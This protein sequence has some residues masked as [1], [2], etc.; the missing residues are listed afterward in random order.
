M[1]NYLEKLNDKQKEACIDVYGPS[2]IIA[3]AGSGKTRVLTNR[4]AYMIDNEKINPRNI[5]AITFTNKA[6]KEMKTRLIDMIGDYSGVVTCKTFH[7]FG[8]DILRRDIESLN[9]RKKSFQIIDDDESEVIVKNVM[10]KLNMDL[11]ITKPKTFLNSISAIKSKIKTY[12]DYEK[13]YADKLRNI[14][15]L[16]NEELKKN[17]LLDFDDLIYLPI[18]IFDLYPEILE[19]YQ[20]RYKYIMVDEFQD[21]SNIQYEFVEKLGRKHRNVFIV[22]DEDQSIY[23]FRGANI[24]NIRKFME[25]FPEYHKHV[26]D[27]NYRSTQSILTCANNLIKNNSDRI[28]KNLWTASKTEGEVGLYQFES[29]YAETRAVV[30]IIKAGIDSGKYKYSDYAILYRNNALSRIFEQELLFSNIPHRVL[31]GLSFYKRMEVKD[32][33]GFLRLSINPNDFYSFKRVCNVPPKGLGKTTID[34]IEERM[35]INGGNLKD[36]IETIE[37]Y[38]NTRKALRDF[39]AFI[40]SIVK[41]LD[42]NTVTLK[43]VFEYVYKESGYKKYLEDIEDENERESRQQNI[44]ELLSAI[45]EEE[46]TESIKVTLADFLQNVTLLTDQD[47]EYEDTNYVSL[48]SMHSAKG[49]EFTNVFAVCLEDEVLPGGKIPGMDEFYE[50]RRLFYVCL[51]RAKENLYIMYSNSRILYGRTESFYPSRFLKELKLET[52][53]EKNNPDRLSMQTKHVTREVP[54]GD[55]KPGDRIIHTMLGEGVILGQAEGFYIVRY[56]SSP[57]PKKIIIGHPMLKKK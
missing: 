30:Q 21:T 45:S 10:Q 43:D 9:G 22:G 31:S 14:F 28:E 39:Y 8:A 40:E 23:S 41:L 24:K 2:L 18:K 19:K 44:K 32:M 17:N 1:K 57:N 33:M 38:D 7:S 34:K 46:S 50:E 49:L 42:E 52:R 36:A 55:L 53:T 54:V 5:L 13:Y 37:I 12:N 11:K 3:G 47:T 35:N 27:Q 4:I 51:T 6:A 16:Y 25:D 15:D 56:D 29:G 26:L 20:D 48:I